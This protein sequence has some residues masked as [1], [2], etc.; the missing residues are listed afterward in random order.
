M[1]QPWPPARHKGTLYFLNAA[2]KDFIIQ[3]VQQADLGADLDFRVG[4]SGSNV[5][6]DRH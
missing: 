4:C 2:G 3:H 1:T 6:R 5:A